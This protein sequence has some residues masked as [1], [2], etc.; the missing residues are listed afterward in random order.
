MPR[1]IDE[2]PVLAVVAS[3]AEGETVIRGAAELRVKESDRIDALVRGLADLGV[4]VD[5]HPDGLVVRG[6]APLGG[7]RVD[8]R[9]DHRIAMS[10]AVAG[11]L[12]PEKVTVGGWS[13]VETSFPGFSELL[14]RAQTR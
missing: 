11:L 5:A 13:C 7:G 1:L 12:T 6:P 8:S 2:I 9:S 3:Q 4:S 14:A 10:F